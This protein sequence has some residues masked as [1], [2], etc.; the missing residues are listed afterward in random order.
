MAA[1]GVRRADLG[2]L[3]RASRAAAARAA[4]GPAAPRPPAP[5]LLAAR[6]RPGRDD[7]PGRRSGVWPAALT[8]GAFPPAVMRV[9]I[10]ARVS[11]GRPGKERGQGVSSQ[12]SDTQ[13]GL[14]GWGVPRCRRFPVASPPADPGC[15]YPPPAT[16]SPRT[17]STGASGLARAGIRWGTYVIPARQRRRSTATYLRQSSTSRSCRCCT[18]RSPAAQ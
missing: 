6:A 9:T 16:R 17:S 10:S 15:N 4:P 13:R 18:R 8:P 1:R 2:L 3:Q 14:P 12:T 11:P 5:A 7:R